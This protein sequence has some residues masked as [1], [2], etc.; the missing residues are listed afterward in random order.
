MKSIGYDPPSRTLAVEFQSGAIYRYRD[1]PSELYQALVCA[2][3]KGRFFNQAIRASFAFAR[4]Q[5]E[6]SPENDEP[7]G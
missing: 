2:K 3:S 6:I 1:V 4:D 7:S 5:G